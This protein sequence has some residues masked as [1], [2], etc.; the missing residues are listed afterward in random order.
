LWNTRNVALND[1]AFECLALKPGDRVLEVG[2]GGGYLLGCMAAVLSEGLLAGVDAS[3]AMVA[4]CEKR[5]RRL[6]EQGRLELRCASAES[7]PYP[8]NYFTRACS[9]NSIFYWQNAARAIAE[10]WRVLAEGGTLVLCFTCKQSLGDRAFAAHGLVLYEG[11]EV[12]RMM[13]AAG[14]QQIRLLRAADQH[15]EFTCVV[16]RK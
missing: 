11:D 4:F 3:P 1:A 8:P 2:F 13:E 12:Q 15:R 5:H 6:I 16:G 10:L 7:L 14:F 9:V